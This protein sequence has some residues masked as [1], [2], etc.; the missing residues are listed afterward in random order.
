MIEVEA[1]EFRL[2]TKVTL[3]ICGTGFSAEI[4]GKLGK[5]WEISLQDY[6][7]TVEDD[8]IQADGHGNIIAMFDGSAVLPN[9]LHW[10]LSNDIIYI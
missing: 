7:Y 6:R 1:L 2:G 4:T 5:R 3:K 9:T 10:L 8:N